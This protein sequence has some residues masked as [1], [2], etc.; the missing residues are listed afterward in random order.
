MQIAD[1]EGN[2][3]IEIAIRSTPVALCLDDRRRAMALVREL[4]TL[5]FVDTIN[6]LIGTLYGPENDSA[7]IVIP[8]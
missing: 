1:L 5:G 2:P 3:L 6:P 4:R 7:G 8:A